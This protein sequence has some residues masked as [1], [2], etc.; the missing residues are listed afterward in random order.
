[1]PTP[2]PVC[3]FNHRQ[4]VPCLPLPVDTSAQKEKNTKSIFFVFIFGI[5]KYLF[6]SA[7]FN[8]DTRFLFG[9]L[10]TGFI[11]S[12]FSSYPLC[13]PCPPPDRCVIFNLVLRVPPF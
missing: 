10:R 9:V 12:G 6:R 8:V 4:R 7:F 11:F 1:M 13:K 5:K 3:F 2:R